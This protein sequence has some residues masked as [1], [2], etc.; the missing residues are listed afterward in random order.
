M[1]REVTSR[2]AFPSRGGVETTKGGG[3]KGTMDT[4]A[5]VCAG[6][7]VIF[8]V[9][10]FIGKFA[11]ETARVLGHHPS[12]FVIAGIAL[13]TAGIFVKVSAR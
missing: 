6:A 9:V 3:M 5:N 7:A 12:S 10:A 11:G 1:A 2:G 8:Y 4:L 13:M